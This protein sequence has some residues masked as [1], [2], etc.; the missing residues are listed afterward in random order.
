MLIKGHFYMLVDS[1]RPC[2]HRYVGINESDFSVEATAL[3]LSR[4]PIFWVTFLDGAI[5]VGN[6]NVAD[7]FILSL[8][9]S[10][11]FLWII[12]EPISVISLFFPIKK[13]PYF[14]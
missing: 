6:I 9:I 10:G 13:S 4:R 1:E 5:V 2:L 11:L 14:I 3:S 12:L 7:Q 8:S